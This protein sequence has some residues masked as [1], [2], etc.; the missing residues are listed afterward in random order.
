LAL[1]I[2][3]GCRTRVRGGGGVNRGA[4]DAR[5]SVVISR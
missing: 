3:W 4:L 5:S 2:D 1:H